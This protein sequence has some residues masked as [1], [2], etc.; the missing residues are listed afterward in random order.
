M[1]GIGKVVCEFMLAVFGWEM[2]P[3]AAE[4]YLVCPHDD[5][6]GLDA[7]PMPPLDGQPRTVP[8][9]GVVALETRSPSCASTAVGW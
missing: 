7:G 4:G 2:Q 6:P 5:G 3:F 1:H 9:I 8:I